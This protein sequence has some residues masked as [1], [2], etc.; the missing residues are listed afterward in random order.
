MHDSTLMAKRASGIA[1]RWLLG[2]LATLT[3]SST[4]GHPGEAPRPSVTNTPPSITFQDG[5]LTV[6]T[7]KAP[8]HQVMERISQLSGVQVRWMEPNAGEQEVS[9]ALTNCPIA[10]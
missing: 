2:I 4:A 8:L 3:F 7:I 9:V 6:H 5:K 10:E 1:G